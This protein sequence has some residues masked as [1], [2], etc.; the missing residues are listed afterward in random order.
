MVRCTMKNRIYFML[1]I[2]LIV[3]SACED[4]VG[5]QRFD[6]EYYVIT[7][8]LYD[9]QTIDQDNGIFIGKSIDADGGN[10]MD[11]FIEPDSLEVTVLEEE[12]DF[13]IELAPFLTIDS[14]NIS[15]QYYDATHSL[16]IKSGYTYKIKVKIQT[17]DGIDTLWAETTVPD[18]INICENS[19]FTFEE[20]QND[21][22]FPEL[23]YDNA[24]EEYPLKI[25]TYSAETIELYFQFYC[26]E[27]FE[28]AYYIEDYPGL[29]D[30]PETQDEY[31]HPVY[32]TPRKIEYYA[33]Y[34]PQMEDGKY[35]I[36]DTSY[37][38]NFI[39]WG[40]YRLRA[41]SIDN[42][43]YSYLYK[44]EGY[45]HGGIESNEDNAIGYFGS[46]SGNTV[47]TKVV[48]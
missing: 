35:Y 38:S 23:S 47:Y 40:K 20:P 31:E 15:L 12:T 24:N 43:Y 17:F 13:E 33:E 7:G 45:N 44:P 32:G 9:N 34:L 29:G 19:A 1:I 37:A 10:L 46:V 18:S 4:N 39:F 36:T 41:Y 8:L 22:L 14:T 6:D 27:E 25:Q 30:Q 26:L 11:S 28:D 3:I 5:P 42:N 2:A 16:T 48:E 21:S